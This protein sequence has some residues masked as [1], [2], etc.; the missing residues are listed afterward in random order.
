[1]RKDIFCRRLL[2]S[3]LILVTSFV[4]LASPVY[5]WRNIAGG[6]FG[7]DLEW[8]L[9]R[10]GVL[11]ISG[12]GEIPDHGG[13]WFEIRGRIRRIVIEEGITGIG[14]YAFQDHYNLNGVWIADT[15]TYIEDYAFYCCDSLKK[16]KIPEQVSYISANA[17]NRCSDLTGIWVDSDNP[18]YS[19]DE[20]GVLFNQE[21]TM[22]KHAP[23][24]LAGS[25]AVPDGVVYV[26]ENAFYD[27]R[28]LTEITLPD[29]L[30]SIGDNAFQGC[31]GLRS[32]TIPD[33]VTV[34]GDDAFY[35]CTAL[36]SVKLPVG[37]THIS[38]QMFFGCSSLA[39]ITLPQGIKGIH[40]S[41]FE[42]SGLRRVTL[43][44]GMVAISEYAFEYCR[45]LISV[46]IPKSL[47]DIGYQAF[48][49]C[50]ALKNVYYRGSEAEWAAISIVDDNEPLTNANIHF[51]WVDQPEI[52]RLENVTDG[53]RITWDA[54]EGAQRYRVYAKTSKGW[55]RLG[56]T[57]DT[58][59]TWTGAKEGQTYTF[60]IRCVNAADNAFT[61]SYNTSGWSIKRN[62]SRKHHRGRPG[63]VFVSY[64][65]F[66]SSRS[67]RRDPA[68]GRIL[69]GQTARQGRESG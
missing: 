54:V 14:R 61:S 9:S 21:K 66:Y 65:W 6:S 19:S 47:K 27:C 2:I 24:G 67:Y 48:Y 37:I 12:N 16:I 8:T 60:A 29:G 59:F 68:A 25:Y 36:E 41:A 45:N 63:G 52:T 40:A 3:L 53:I 64:L 7:A 10:K 51:G 31:T 1:M 50:S 49:D 20:Y 18:Y 23:G 17:F 33:S 69:L 28:E 11:T 34:I 46:E 13:P 39:E 30:H 35:D 22:L 58:S 43:P 44:E 56:S 5:A 42:S 57:T 4:L 55:L 62:E 26:L 32:V 15:V 38:K